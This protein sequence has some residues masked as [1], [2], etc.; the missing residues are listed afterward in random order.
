MEKTRFHLT[1]HPELYSKENVKWMMLN[2]ICA[3]IPIGVVS[4]YYFGIKVLLIILVSTITAVASEAFVQKV[5][6]RIETTALDGSAVVTGLL[7]A[8]CLPPTVPLWIPFIG[9][10][11]AIIIGKQLFGGLGYNVFNPALVGRAILLLSWSSEMT[12]WRLPRGVS[13]AVSTATPLALA[14][15]GETLPSNL[16]MLIGQRSGCI[17]ET[18]AILIVLGGLYLIFRKISTWHVPVSYL[19]TVAILTK[20][21]GRDP[22]FYLLAG[23]LLLGVFFMATDPVTI[24]VTNKGRFIFGLGAGVMTVLIRFY[25]SNF[26]ESVCYSILFMNCITPLIDKFVRTQVLEK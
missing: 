4:I 13:D 10:A 15:S 25:S 18:C 1:T 21:L 9:S 14:K 26:V 23:G 16:Q 2:V 7:L 3:L 12:K 8:F 11:I 20:I 5:F 24:P 22:V 6:L 19:I 17:G